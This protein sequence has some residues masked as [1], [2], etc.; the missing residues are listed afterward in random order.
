MKT[1]SIFLCLLAAC[2]SSDKLQGVTEDDYV[3]CEEFC[4]PY[5]IKAWE[6]TDNYEV[7]YCNTPRKD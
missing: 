3:D 4:S 2:S 5:G 1:V 7:C 6:K